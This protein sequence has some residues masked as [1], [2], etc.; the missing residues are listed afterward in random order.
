MV[1]ELRVTPFGHHDAA[2]RHFD[3]LVRQGFGSIAGFHPDDAVWRRATLAVRS[4]GLG[5]RSTAEHA[6][7]AWVASRTTTA[8]ACLALDPDYRWAGGD[9]APAAALDALS[10]ALGAAAVPDGWAPQ[11]C[12]ELALVLR[13]VRCTMPSCDVVRAERVQR[14]DLWERYAKEREARGA[15]AGAG[16]P[17]TLDSGT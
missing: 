8:A 13:Q 11:R 12:A 16:A 17:G 1:F 15:K 4:G 9:H 3:G 14:P 2:L 5:L 7:A 6:A 10:D